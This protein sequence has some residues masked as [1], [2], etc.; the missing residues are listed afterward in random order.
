MDIQADLPCNL[1]KPLSCLDRCVAGD[2][3]P[4]V[5]RSSVLIDVLQSNLRLPC[6]SQTTE[7]EDFEHILVVRR[8]AE[9][10]MNLR[11]VVF[12]TTICWIPGIRYT[13][14]YHCYVVLD[15]RLS[16]DCA[17]LDSGRRRTATCDSI[18]KL[19]MS[20]LTQQHAFVFQFKVNTGIEILQS[21]EGRSMGFLLSFPSKP[22]QKSL[23]CL[24]PSHPTCRSDAQ[25]YVFFHA[26]MSSP[27][28]IQFPYTPCIRLKLQ[29]EDIE[30]SGV[31]SSMIYGEV[32]CSINR[33]TFSGQT[34]ERLGSPLST[35]ERV[36][37]LLS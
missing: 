3:K 17:V 16:R 18:K 22:S 1:H 25:A 9:T 19:T 13:E 8:W 28:E 21:T 33:C 26:Q 4:G 2:P 12:S 10:I 34:P 29:D 27:Y 6:A 20:L 37:T 23:K 31:D 14:W 15:R 24:S 35:S 30:N 36:N 32:G 5:I 7:S 11:K